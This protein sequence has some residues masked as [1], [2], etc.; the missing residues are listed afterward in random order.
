MKFWPVPPERRPLSW[1]G[2]ALVV[3]LAALVHVLACAHGPAA[4]GAGRAD[5]L[6][7]VSAA[8]CGEPAAPGGDAALQ[9]LDPSGGGGAHCSGA[10]GPT[11]GPPRDIAPAA[12]A[13][14]PLPAAQRV[15]ALSG[16]PGAHPPPF[17][18]LPLSSVPQE[19]A[20]LGVWRT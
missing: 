13:A 6:L 20:R 19:R 1:T 2:A 12:E 17:S 4:A 10:D 9:G 11:A 8:S 16:Q 18:A 3:L 14:H 15:D 7:V 5:A